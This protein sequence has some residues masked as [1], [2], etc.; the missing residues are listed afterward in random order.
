MTIPVVGRVLAIDWG[1][2]RIGLALSDETQLLATPFGVLQRRAGKRLPLG[3]FLT[4]I[5]TERPVGLVVGLPLDDDG[6]LG[7]P[8]VRAREMGDLFAVRANLP[9]EW[10]D[11]SFTTTEAE[12]RLRERGVAPRHR[13][14]DIDALAAAVL[15]ERW[16]AD[17]RG[18][19]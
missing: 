12:H 1:Q 19:P 4:I 14:D 2:K 13:R 15:L 5:E 6:H 9:L 3:E 16:L 10:V 7:E 8:A 17:R 11:E 18:A